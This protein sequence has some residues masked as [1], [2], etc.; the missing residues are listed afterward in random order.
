MSWY[1][2]FQGR[3]P[4]VYSTWEACHK[5]VVG[6]KNNCYK[7]YKCQEE[8]LKAYWDFQC[9]KQVGEDQEIKEAKLDKQATVIDWKIVVIAI[10]FVLILVLVL[11]YGC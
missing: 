8:A 10:Q 11:N 9:A 2:V 3:R 6:Y 5:Q 7:C 4:G 1:V